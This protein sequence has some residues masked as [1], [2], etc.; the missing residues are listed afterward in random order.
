MTHTSFIPSNFKILIV[1]DSPIQ[2]E[3]LRRVLTREGYQI[4]LAKNGVEGLAV[5]KQQQPDLILS[6]I[7]MPVMDGFEMCVNIRKDPVQGEQCVVM[8]TVLT[9]ITDVIK[10]LN[11]GADNYLT[12]PYKEETLLNHVRNSLMTETYQENEKQ[13]FEICL[14]D[15]TLTQ[16]RASPRQTL[17]LLVSTYSNMDDQNQTLV[18]NQDEL[19]SL[20]A[21]LTEKVKNQTAELQINKLKTRQSFVDSIKAIAATFEM[22]DTYT[23]GHQRRAAEISVLIAQALGLSE[24]RVFGLHLATLVHDIGEINTPAEILNKHSELTNKQYAL[25]QEHA[26]DGYNILKNIDFPWPIAEMVL[27]HHERLDGSGYPNGLKGDD[28]LYESRIIMVADVV[29]AMSSDRPYR[30]CLGLDVVK[31][32]L[33][34][35]RGKFYQ[36]EIVDICIKLINQEKIVVHSKLGH[37]YE[38]RN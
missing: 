2:A 30:A 21:S 6:D 8:L 22:R 37:T 15:G 4:S 28:I 31:Q 25:V 18:K 34:K 9:E 1:E 12:K 27:Q 20:N 3:M 14:P 10:A 7:S 33:L 16:V 26:E 11:A 5:V 36:P 35:N 32:E 17:N 19:V 24:D 13:D 38:Y 29:E 23:A